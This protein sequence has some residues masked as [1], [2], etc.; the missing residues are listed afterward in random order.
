MLFFGE[1]LG[2]LDLRLRSPIIIIFRSR[3]CE[4]TTEQSRTLE[5][6]RNSQG[7]KSGQNGEKFGMRGEKSGENGE[8]YCMDTRACSDT[9]IDSVCKRIKPEEG[10]LVWGSGPNSA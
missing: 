1:G 5:C 10:G 8:T 9:V 7:E 6:N 3:S 4:Q 2:F